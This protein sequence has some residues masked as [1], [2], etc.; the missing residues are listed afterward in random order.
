M[1]RSAPA[2]F[3]TSNDIQ[4]IKRL[5]CSR[6]LTA[7]VRGDDLEDGRV[8]RLLAHP[9]RVGDLAGDLELGV[10]DV[11]YDYLAGPLI[12]H[13]PVGSQKNSPSSLNLND[14]GLVKTLA[15]VCY[16]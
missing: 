5:P 7:D 8:R 2:M 13:Y 3:K 6:A 12:D 11:P 9:H 10:L 4:A 15:T 16:L 14:L 1:I